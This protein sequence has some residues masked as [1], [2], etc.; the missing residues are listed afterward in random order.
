LKRELREGAL[1]A[2]SGRCADV[3]REPAKPRLRYG[4]NSYGL[5]VA[6]QLNAQTPETKAKPTSAKTCTGDYCHCQC[7]EPCGANVEISFKPCE[8]IVDYQLSFSP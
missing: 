8:R 5:H 1:A 4:G 3:A 6:T 2:V 7:S